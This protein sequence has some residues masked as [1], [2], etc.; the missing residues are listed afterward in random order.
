MLLFGIDTAVN[1]DLFES[2]TRV[3]PG[4]VEY[5]YPG[6]A[7]EHRVNLQFERAGLPLVK[8]FELA[9][10]DHRLLRRFPEEAFSLHSQD[11]QPCLLLIDGP[12][13]E[14][15]TV[16]V[17]DSL[18]RQQSVGLQVHALD[19]ENA[20]A[21][22][23]LYADQLIRHYQKRYEAA[24]MQHNERH[25]NRLKKEI[26]A[27]GLS[28][29][30]QT[31]FTAWFA[32][33]DRR[34]KV[35]A[36]PRIQVIPVE[37]PESW[38]PEVL[39]DRSLRLPEEISPLRMP[40]VDAELLR[41]EKPLFKMRESAVYSKPSTQPSFVVET[42]LSQGADG[43]IVPKA[44]QDLTPTTAT[45]LSLIGLLAMARQLNLELDAYRSNIRQ[46]IGFAV[47]QPDFGQARNQQLAACVSS[48]LEQV[49]LPDARLG[50]VTLKT[51]QRRRILA[52]LKALPVTGKD[53]FWN[54]LRAVLE[55]CG[56][57][58]A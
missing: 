57:P 11:C 10:K 50:A 9:E 49:G 32:E 51:T 21:L 22:V 31:R 58:V 28:H 15:L 54:Q 20:S 26:V 5:I 44:L 29:Q 56:I 46:A 12:P 4:T 40:C 55:G 19:K 18:H 33:F 6:E 52:R 1:Q 13:P 45:L 47:Q 38:V 35:D 17:T 42:L 8:K 3:C 39:F 23:K 7:L 48:L 41:P 53:A 16:L 2:I 25:A 30:L 27:I 37:L 14:S 43:R 24:R 36:L 34:E